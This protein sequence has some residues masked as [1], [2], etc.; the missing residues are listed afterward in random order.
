[1]YGTDL[2]ASA[3]ADPLVA[4]VASREKFRDEYRK[5]KTR[6]PKTGCCGGAQT[7]R[8]LTHVLPGQSILELGLR[9]TRSSPT[10]W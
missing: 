1:V 7:F 9:R 2:P 10:R 3:P 8:H 6:S 5:K 4:S